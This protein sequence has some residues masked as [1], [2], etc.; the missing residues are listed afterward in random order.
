[1]VRTKQTARK[2]TGG[3]A[4]Q[5]S[6]FILHHTLFTCKYL[7]WLPVGLVINTCTCL[8]TL[9]VFREGR[10]LKNGI[11]QPHIPIPSSILRKGAGG[12]GTGGGN[13][14][15]GGVGNGGGGG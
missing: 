6:K 8:Y 3:R 9:F 4:T 2:N 13:G 5:N 15:G 11:K 10:K 14:G 7:Y 12:G 1:M